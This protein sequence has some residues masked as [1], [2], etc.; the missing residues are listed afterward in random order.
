MRGTERFARRAD[1]IAFQRFFRREGERMEHKIDMIGF[2]AHFFEKSLDLGVARHVARE[3]RRVLSELAD[4]FFHIFFQS[5]ALIIE[6]QSR[7][8]GG[9]GLGN[10][11]GDT[12]LVRHSE[13][14][15]GLSCQYLLNHKRKD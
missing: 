6:N 3:K 4:E 15:A 11:P 12:A 1:E 5:L 9:P 2:A 7:A 10:R 14:Y 8:G 13:D